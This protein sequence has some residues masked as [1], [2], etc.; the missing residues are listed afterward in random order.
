[1]GGL[2]VKKRTNRVVACLAALAATVAVA[3]PAG[4]KIRIKESTSYYSI[5]GRSGA[6]LGRA[7]V[8]G[9]TRT[10]RLDH[11]IAA[12]ATKFSFENP[13]IDVQRGSC[14]LK[15]V[16]VVLD[17]TYYFPRW[18]GK[19]AASSSLRGSWD[20][21]YTEL[22]R[23]EQTHGSI[24]KR[25]AQR[26]E[27]EMLGMRGN[28]SL[29]CRDFGANAQRRFDQLA[30]QLKGQQASFDAREQFSSSKIS[31]LQARLLGTR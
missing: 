25:F 13:S 18:E 6:E 29:G 15:K 7:M 4:A 8:S 30:A 14:V 5:S 10:T 22:V 2:V 26:V 31:Q 11:A 21:F 17:I 23:H 16:D 1:M 9:G 24:A 3:S 27:K 20:R 19:S 28:V 12:T